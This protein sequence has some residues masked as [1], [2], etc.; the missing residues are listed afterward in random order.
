[1]VGADIDGDAINEAKKLSNKNLKFKLLNLDG[2]FPF[3]KNSF[4]V[5]VANQIY[6]HAKNPKLLM[7]EIYRVLKPN[8]ICF[9]G[10][11]NR[12]IVRDAHYPHLPFVSWLPTWLSNYYVSLFNYGEYYEPR[13]KTVF[14]IRK[15]INKFIVDDYTLKV[16]K[17]PEKF[18]STDVIKKNSLITKLPDFVLR[19]IYPIIPNYLLILRK[20]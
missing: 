16:I 10:A 13:L 2:S 19:L 4:D 1:M 9:F 8:G 6:E 7:K 14:G 12:L 5:I 18:N 20:K 3:A 11:G 17:R 15:M